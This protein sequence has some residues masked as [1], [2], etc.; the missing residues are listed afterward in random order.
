MQVS[1]FLVEATYDDDR[2]ELVLTFNHPVAVA[3]EYMEY[4][5]RMFTLLYPCDHTSYWA[6]DYFEVDSKQGK[7]MPYGQ[8]VVLPV[9]VQ[10]GKDPSGLRVVPNPAAFQVAVVPTVA[11]TAMLKPSSVPHP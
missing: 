5:L 8:R 11:G 6:D 7:V 1:A 3:E 10:K 9:K 2:A 4:P